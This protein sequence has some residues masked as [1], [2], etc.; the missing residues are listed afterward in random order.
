MHA[1]PT[2][3]SITDLLAKRLGQRRHAM[4]FGQANLELNDTGLAVEAGSQFAADWINAHFE[5]DLE[6]VAQDVVGGPVRVSIS[7]RS[8]R[9][10]PDGNDDSPQTLPPARE[11]RR[12]QRPRRRTFSN[13]HKLEDFIVGPSNELAWSAASRIA[14]EAGPSPVSPLFI[15]GGCGLGKT[16]LL[17]GVCRRYREQFGQQDPI[18]YLTGEQFTNEYIASVRENKIDEFRRSMRR[19][20]LLAIDDIHFLSDKTKTQAEFLHTLDAIHLTGSRIVLASDAHPHQIRSFTKGLVSRFLSGMV[21]EIERPCR[22]TRRTLVNRFADHRG[23]RMDESAVE[24]VTSHCVGSVREIQ[25]AMTRLSALMQVR[26]SGS[27]HVPADTVSQVF[28]NAW[29]STQPITLDRIVETVCDH[30]NLTKADLASRDRGT[31]VSLGR[32]L[33]ACL[34]RRMTDYSYPEIARSLGRRN[35]SS[36]HAAAR[37][38]EAMVEDKTKVRLPGQGGSD[39][40][41]VLVREVLDRLRHAISHP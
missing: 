18:R 35:H 13:H 29:E 32:G 25:G 39:E 36:A 7:V 21:V 33:I 8:D 15:H 37:R 22:H 6:Q 5:R 26:G 28:Q 3:D 30:L 31:R 40:G 34:A 27:N 14:G 17:Q 1:L 9:P 23:L 19:L 24:V 16:H 12:P 10:G 38:I 41:H 2:T 4:W 11:E 20:S